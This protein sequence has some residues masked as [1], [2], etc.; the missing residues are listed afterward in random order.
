MIM[1]LFCSNKL[2]MT[3]DMSVMELLTSAN[4]EK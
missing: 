4:G 2:K 3:G 1:K